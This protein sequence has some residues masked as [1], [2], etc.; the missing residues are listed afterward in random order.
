MTCTS[1]GTQ[2]EAGRKF[3]MECGQRLAE[4][5]PSCGTINAAGAKFCGEC[6]EALGA[7]SPGAAAPATP[8]GAV[9]ATPAGAS[10]VAERRLV[11]VLFTDLVG[12]TSLAENRDAEDTRDMLSG[13]F[14]AAREI[15]G[16]HGGVIEKFIGDAVMAVWGT[17]TAHEDDAERAVRTALQLVEA[18][19]QME[20]GGQH[21]QARAG[22]LTGEAAVTIGATGQGMVAGDLVNTASRLQS[23]AAPGT[24]LVGESTY[25][26]ALGAIAFEAAGEHQ[27]K[28]KELPVPAWRALAVVARRGGSGRAAQ[29]E[30]PFVGRDEELRTLREQFHATAREGKP[31]L[32]TIVGQAG[33]GKSRLGWELEKYL[34]GVVESIFWHEGR[35]PSYGEGISYWALAEMVR[36]R[37]GIAESDDPET[38]RHRLGEMLAQFV[39]DATERRWIEPRLTGLL[40]L[41][42]LPTESREEL[43]AAWR[44]FFERMAA[45]ATVL[46][47]FWDLQWADQGL[48]DFIEHLLTWA[49]TSPI[50]VLAE[51]R[52]ELF[53]RRPGWGVTVRSSTS[54]HLEPLSDADM[55]SL[56]AGLV[57]GLPE[58]ALK[59]IVAR[60]EGV[61]LYAVETLR[62]LIDRDVLQPESDGAQF[63]LVGDLPELAV[64]ETLHALI[65]A[66]LDAL[67]HDER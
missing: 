14:E 40:G 28:G 64:P 23:A 34:D 47:V 5:C 20:V 55:R 58:H 24:V 30:P 49:R 33:I 21:L 13:Y 61:P 7:A 36:G 37:A 27:M 18:V 53:E 12:S 57:P 19:G 48:L 1:C 8:A 54:V 4:A 67:S 32:V 26:A 11:S 50:F 10:P 2:N 38:A 51:A 41:E 60:A 3:C 52:P 31:R 66:R 25:R 17:P 59:A 56:L 46:L 39:P 15:V 42:D 29:L 16:R 45:Q 22:V 9:P 62:M 63:A 44:T 6:G 43:F 65:A 35:S